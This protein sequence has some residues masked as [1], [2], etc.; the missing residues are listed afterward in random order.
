MVMVGLEHCLR[1]IGIRL[2][3]LYQ[4][5]LNPV[6]LGWA[7][8]SPLA[9]GALDFTVTSA[10]LTLAPFPSIRFSSGKLPCHASMMAMSGA[11]C[12]SQPL[13]RGSLC[14]HFR[15]FAQ[16][17]A[18]AEE[19][20]DVLANLHDQEV[21]GQRVHVVHVVA[22]V[23]ELERS[24]MLG[25]Q[26]PA[27]GRTYAELVHPDAVVAGEAACL[28]VR[29]DLLDAG[30]ASHAGRRALLAV[31]EPGTVPEVAACAEADSVQSHSRLALADG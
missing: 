24:A 10:A 30:V 27:E 3:G 5:Y 19:R 26:R 15:A 6:P 21:R 9:S 20:P 8:A 28:A 2:D 11:I 22:G 13:Q 14:S 12:S 17:P 7:T 18:L 16:L 31:A 4:N 29:A 25:R 1:G 23:V